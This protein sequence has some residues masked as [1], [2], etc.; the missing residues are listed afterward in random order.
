MGVGR[1]RESVYLA[2][3]AS[4]QGIAGRARFARRIGKEEQI[5]RRPVE[6]SGVYLGKL[7]DS[8]TGSQPAV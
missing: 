4:E 2:M 7:S 3:L 1:K 8:G 6:F 5:V